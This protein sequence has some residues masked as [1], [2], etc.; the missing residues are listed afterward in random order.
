MYTDTEIQEL[1]HLYELRDIA[2]ARESLFDFTGFTMPD[3]VPADFH[4]VYYRVLDSFSK[5]DIKKLMITMP[6][7]HGKSEGSTRRLPAYMLGRNPDA[8]IAIASY[9]AT[10]AEEF[11]TDIQKIIDSEAYHKVFPETY[12]NESNVVT[13]S[14]TAKR[15]SRKFEIVGHRGSLK[16]VGRGGALTGSSVDVMIMDDLYK[17]YE[18][19]NSPI[20]RD[21]VWNWYT[22]VVKTRLHNDSQE[23]IVFTRWHE[24]DLI[25]RLEEK[26]NVITITNLDDIDNLQPT[27]WVKIN[28]E[29]IK[30]DKATDIDPR[31]TS[32]PLWP[33]RHSLAK[34]EESKDL[35]EDE[36]EC[37]YQGDPV[38]SKGLLYKEF[39]T[40]ESLPTLYDKKNYTD[41]AD[42]GTDYLCSIC[43]G[44]KDGMYYV[45]DVVYTDEPMEET[46]ISVPKMLIDNDTKK[47]DIESNNGGRSFARTIQKEVKGHCAVDWFYQSANKEAR[48]NSN[49]NLVIQHVIMPHDWIKRWPVFAKHVRKFKRLFRANKQDGGPDVLTGIIEKN[50]RTKRRAFIGGS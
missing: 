25:G 26:N 18:E 36:F 28:F 7:Q 34:L 33:A 11:N 24:D 50:Q 45:T 14:G 39:Q 30:T 42:K 1:E 44:V 40:Y 29:A 27:D 3:F 10:F 23:L 48:I 43:Y 2:A 49:N 19:G 32:E 37:L 31:E 47:A 15:N 22:T 4:K 20:V 8:K 41:T 5:G 35:G 13:I 9:N 21:S 46:E 6:P 12:L 38:S 16:A 17:D